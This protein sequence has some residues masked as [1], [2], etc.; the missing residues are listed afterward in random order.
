MFS[1]IVFAREEMEN[2]MV[3]AVLLST[4]LLSILLFSSFKITSTTGGISDV[5][6]YVSPATTFLYDTTPVGTRFNITVMW[7]DSGTPLNDVCGWQVSLDIDTMMLN[8]TRAWQPT[9]DPNYLL[10]PR[11]PNWTHALS[12]IGTSRILICGILGPPSPPPVRAA[13]AK[14]AIFEL[15]IAHAL[16]KGDSLL[17][18]INSSDATWT[19]D[20]VKSYDPK[21]ANGKLQVPNGPPKFEVAP[22]NVTLGPG[23]ANGTEFTVDVNMTGPPPS[24]L[25]ACL[26]IIA[27]GFRLYY[28]NTL[29]EPVSL[30]EGSF[31][32]DSAWNLYGTSFSGVFV[33][34]GSGSYAQANDLIYPNSSGHW[35]QMSFPNGTG[36]IARISFRAIEQSKLSQIE[37]NLTLDNCHLDNKDDNFIPM[38]ESKNV[39][40]HYTMLPRVRFL[41]VWKPTSPIPYVPSNITRADEPTRITAN[42]SEPVDDY[43]VSMLL[44]YRVDIGE[45][46]NTSMEYNS[47]TNLWTTQ[48]PGQRN[49]SRVVEFFVTAYFDVGSLR[50][51]AYSYSVKPL[52]GSDIN[53]DGKVDAKDVTYV[54]RDYGKKGP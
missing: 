4:L 41:T 10:K 53:G 8:C 39:N 29:L 50:S 34:D 13:S 23:P 17:L 43:N 48:I 52:L 49:D 40:C 14:L 11:E 38:N 12:G 51:Q 44:S 36:S 18:D 24:G 45:W 31:F 28:N 27:A 1:R 33:S 9:W 20:L 19:P 32:Q 7:R 21:K 5:E 35:D 6:F 16:N 47:S 26:S 15:E 54:C 2:K 22:S 30:T 46:W 37:C 3:S 42:F 25:D